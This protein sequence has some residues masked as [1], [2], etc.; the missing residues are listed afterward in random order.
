MEVSWTSKGRPWCFQR[1]H[2]SSVEV[3]R[4]FAT[5]DLFL[6]AIQ[7]VSHRSCI[8]SL[9]ISLQSP[10][11]WRLIL[12]L[13]APAHARWP[14]DKLGRQPSPRIRDGREEASR[15]DGWS[16]YAKSCVETSSIDRGGVLMAKRP[17]KSAAAL[18]WWC[19]LP[20]IRTGNRQAC[21]ASQQELFV[22]HIDSSIVA[23]AIIVGQ[24]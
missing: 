19:C 13:A 20:P 22:S 12:Q 4:P 5:T 11:W 21:P 15:R 16:S 18:H 3:L 14:D 6:R 8:R 7:R 1:K 24:W 2:R 23:R 17:R 10:S 9:L